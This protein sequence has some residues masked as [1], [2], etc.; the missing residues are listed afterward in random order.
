M[1]DF[2]KAH[3]VQVGCP[4]PEVPAA[5]VEP[6]DVTA[7]A[8]ESTWDGYAGALQR[9][10]QLVSAAGHLLGV[11]AAV[12]H[13]DVLASR[14]FQLSLQAPLLSGTGPTGKWSKTRCCRTAFKEES[15]GTDSERE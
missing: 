15:V 7:G 2:G 3:A 8:V 12:D 13:E 1:W 4:E 10:M 6:T 9:C 11:L 5:A 14:P